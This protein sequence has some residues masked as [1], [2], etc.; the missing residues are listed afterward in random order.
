MNNLED[1]AASFADE[2]WSSYFDDDFKY[3][4]SE[5][6]NQYIEDNNGE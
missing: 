5:A 4:W 3:A 1:E 2:N 6:Y